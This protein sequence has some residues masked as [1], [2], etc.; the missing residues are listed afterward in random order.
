MEDIALE[1]IRIRIQEEQMR[2]IDNK[3][4]LIYF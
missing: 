1:D 2:G 3:D 4:V